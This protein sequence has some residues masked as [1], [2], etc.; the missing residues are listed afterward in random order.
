MKKVLFKRMIII[1]LSSFCLIYLNGQTQTI[2]QQLLSQLHTTTNTSNV[3]TGQWTKIA[4]CNITKEWQDFGSVIDFMGTGSGVE[5]FYY[6]RIIAR[7]KNQ[8]NSAQPVNYY[9]LLLLDSNLGSENVKAIRNGLKVE[10]FIKVP[11]NHI[12]VYFKQTLKGNSGSLNAF[13]N[14]PFHVNLPANDLE[15]NC[16]NGLNTLIDGKIGIGTNT[17]REKLEVAGIIRATEVKI[18]AP[19]SDFVFDDDY[20]LR[21]LVEVEQFIKQNRHLPDIKSAAQMKEDEVIGIAEMNNLLLQ[22]IE[23]LTLY[24]IEQNKKIEN[25]QKAF[26][27]LKK[28]LD[29]LKN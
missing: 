2:E 28:E 8:N 10:L 16:I 19:N 5:T 12:I 7:F 26:D 4:E 14:Q 18:M 27:E 11:T 1:A 20:E 3:F 29:M 21:P 9:S 6:G 23:E 17:P 15:I 25:Q 13:S 22:K 24:L